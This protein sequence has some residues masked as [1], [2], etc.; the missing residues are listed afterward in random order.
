MTKEVKKRGKKK[1]SKLYND[2][3]T[4][5]LEMSELK[6]NFLRTKFFLREER[7]VGG[8]DFVFVGGGI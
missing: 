7:Y 3:G 5:N 2:V 6:I 1:Q 4:M 8:I